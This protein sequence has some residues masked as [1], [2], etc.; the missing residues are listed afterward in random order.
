MSALRLIKSRCKGGD[1]VGSGM[2]KSGAVPDDGASDLVWESM[3]GGSNGS[4]WEV[5]GPQLS[6]RS[7]QL[8]NPMDE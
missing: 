4:E 5:E 1:E 7:S 6:A 3:M 2:G 8:N